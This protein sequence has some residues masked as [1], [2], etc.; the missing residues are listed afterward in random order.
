MKTSVGLEFQRGPS[1]VG[2][3]SRGCK[4]SPGQSVEF[5]GRKIIDRGTPLKEN[6]EVFSGI[7][8]PEHTLGKCGPDRA[9]CKDAKALVLCGALAT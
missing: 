4:R 7:Q 9:F 1:G 3:C 5:R 6:I 2:G 8:T